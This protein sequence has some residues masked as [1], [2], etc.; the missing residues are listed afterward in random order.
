MCP[1]LVGYETQS[2]AGVL[3]ANGANATFGRYSGIDHSG[4]YAD[5]AASGQLRSED[6]DYASYDLERLGLASRDG[7]VEGGREGRYDVR[8]S[9]DGQPTRLYD[10]GATPFR[11]NGN[12]LELPQGWV[13]GR[14]HERHECTQR[15]SRACQD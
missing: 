14:K 6:G 15:Q 11:A 12:N 4:A 2:E 8:V 9:Y 7:H 1:F 3:Y 13:P 10:T 5:V